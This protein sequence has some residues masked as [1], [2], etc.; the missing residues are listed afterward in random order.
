MKIF[1]SLVLLFVSIIIY[2]N[3]VRHVRRRFLDQFQMPESVVARFRKKHPNLSGAQERSVIEGLLQYFQVCQRARGKFVSM[4]SQVVDDL[5]HEFILF[6]RLY[7]QFCKKALGKYLHHTPAEA[8]SSPNQVSAG[9]RRTWFHAC[10]IESIDPKHPNRLPLLFALDAQLGI[11]H[12]F[13]YDLNC[14]NTATSSSNAFCASSI[15]CGGSDSGC[16]GDAGDGG[17]SCG[18]GCGG[19][20]D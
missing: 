2:S 1:L 11:Q 4:P 17:S 13:F 12:G 16:A 6:T 9:I 15:A 10:R 7:E 3:W 8:M 18:S 5:W 20:G 19:G 14:A